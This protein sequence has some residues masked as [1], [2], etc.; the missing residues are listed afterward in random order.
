MSFD[1]EVLKDGRGR[2][3]RFDFSTDAFATVYA[4]Y[5]TVAG[6]LDG[7]NWYEA[8]IV[9]CGALRRG[10]GQD[11]IA[12]AGGIDVVVANDDGAADWLASREYMASLAK[13]RVRVY[14]VLFDP[15]APTTFD[16]KQ[17]GEFGLATWPRRNNDA[18]QLSL[19][20]DIMTGLSAPCL[21]PTFADWEAVGTDASNPL[22]QG[23]VYGARTT[24]TSSGQLAFGEDWIRTMD[25][26][27]PK[28]DNANWTERSHPNGSTVIAGQLVIPV[29]VTDDTTTAATSGEIPELRAVLYDSNGVVWLGSPRF[30]IPKTWTYPTGG[31]L[32][33]WTVHRSDTVTVDGRGFKFIYILL[34]T[35]AFHEWAFRVHH[36]DGIWWGWGS[37]SPTID[38]AVTGPDGGPA[39]ASWP[40]DYPNAFLG[41]GDWRRYTTGAS[42]VAEWYVKGNPLSSRQASSFGV[43][44][45]C[46]VIKD[47]CTHYAKPI[48]TVD[49]ANFVTVATATRGA[50]A[51]G[52]IAEPSTAPVPLRAIVSRIC[53]SADLDV[54]VNWQGQ[55]AFA[56]PPYGYEVQDALNADSLVR[57]DETRLVAMEDWIP[58][59]GERG[60][61]YNRV[62]LKGGRGNYAEGQDVPSQGPFTIDDAEPVAILVTDKVVPATLEQGWRPWW[63]TVDNPLQWRYL[64]THARPRV[65][66]TTDISG[67]LLEL[68]QLFRL[69]WTRN[70][71]PALY[72]AVVFQVESIAYAPDS[73]QVEVEAIWRHDVTTDVPY[74]L[75]NESLLVRVASSG[76][77]TATVTD[78]DSTVV[79]AS[80]S[81]VSDGVAVGDILVLLDSTQ[82]A[83]VFTRYRCLRIAEVSSATTLKVDDPDLSFDAPTGAA[84]ATWEIRRGKTTYPTAISD[85]TNYPT[86]SAMYGKV[87]DSGTGLYSDSTTPNLLLD[88]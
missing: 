41:G 12:A 73:D 40:K 74:L 76:G 15:A 86:G 66:F 70:V 5:G 64:E 67:L 82:A 53:Q 10:F 21:L 35:Y 85:P 83:N 43:M 38:F 29:C 50:S 81:L 58:G 51:S 78:G 18:V 87:A 49:S 45:P 37:T 28:T 32:E 57:V 1:T 33:I 52:V 23:G 3:L 61:P 14:V 88:G 63:Q 24:R 47:I 75:D 46:D 7:S 59:L 36:P 26:V 62:T 79:F 11:H 54:F 84:V 42:R 30:D 9:S 16:A 48:L 25:P 65:R 31:E 8:R 19:A 27:F 77:R 34:D 4:R 80:G 6:T 39:W 44:H 71:T 72:D 2:A 56:A 22:H 13:L 17:L 68:G 55:V 69:T 60:A 20:D